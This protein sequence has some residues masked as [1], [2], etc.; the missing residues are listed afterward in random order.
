M[1]T[2]LLFVAAFFVSS[3]ITFAGDLLP[4]IQ[5]GSGWEG[6]FERTDRSFRVAMMSVV[7]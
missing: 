7:I 3:T 2:F 6:T 1:R 5:V 4:T